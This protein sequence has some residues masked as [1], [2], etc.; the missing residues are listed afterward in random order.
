MTTY[1]IGI[2]Q[3]N[4]LLSQIKYNH[5]ITLHVELRKYAISS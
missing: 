5:F 1:W 4:K 3:Q 2:E